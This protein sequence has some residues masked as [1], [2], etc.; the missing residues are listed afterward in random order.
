MIMNFETRPIDDLPS[1]PRTAQTGFT[2]AFGELPMA[3][4]MFKPMD[5]RTVTSVQSDAT[6][7]RKVY[8]N[9]LVHTRIDH[10]KDGVWFYWVP[11]P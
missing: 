5:G 6:Y 4:A 7:L 2:T 8:P 9:R 1:A 11:K 3:L 10:E